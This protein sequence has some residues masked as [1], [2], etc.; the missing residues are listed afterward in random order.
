MHAL[1]F[2]IFTVIEFYA[3][4][5]ALLV[6]FVAGVCRVIRPELCAILETLRGSKH[7]RTGSCR[8]VSREKSKLFKTR[9]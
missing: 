2:D 8:A 6:I 7:G 9:R 4:R 1:N 5:I 3:F